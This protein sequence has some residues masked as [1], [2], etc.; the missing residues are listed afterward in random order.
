MDS[1]AKKIVMLV[2]IILATAGCEKMNDK[3]EPWLKDGEIIYIGKVDSVHT[4]AGNERVMFR[5][6][7]SDPRVK[8][9]S[10]TWSLGRESLEV[11]VPAHLPTDSFE[12]Y[13]GRNEKIIAEGDHTF[14][15]I[16][17]DQHGNKSIVF[18]TTANVYGERYQN[19][20]TNR[21]LISAEADGTDVT[22]TW[23]GKTDNNE[24]GVTVSYTN[25]SD[26]SVTERYTSDEATS[27]VL[28][29]VKLTAP[30]TYTTSFI[31]EATAIDTF[32]T[33][34][35]KASVQSIVNVVL[36]KPTTHSDFNTGGQE[37]QM[38]VNGDRTTSTRWVSDDSN[39]EHWIE[40]D[41]E[42]AF[43]INAFGMWRDM[44]NAAQQMQMFRL[45]AWIDGSWVDV[46][47]EDNNNVA[48]YYIEF[49]SVTTDRVR[50]YIPPY[51]D[52]RVRLCQIEVYSVIKY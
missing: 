51:Q 38:A 13:I 4:F 7:I 44:S 52:N 16:T 28:P 49:D 11:A 40:V 37:G 45:Q 32:S 29:D 33:E 41:L 10:I 48:V 12:L 19:R 6:W 46:V 9:L 35:Q 42:G 43:D 26:V 31:P 24:V 47:S 23:G 30:V 8:T 22:L 17:R 25:T 14:N 50:F 2:C 21:P 20:L 15:L 34:P 5:Y 3:H 27:V 18:E 36:R 1:N 39:N